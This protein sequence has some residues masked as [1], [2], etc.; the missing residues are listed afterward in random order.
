MLRSLRRESGLR[1]A[2]AARAR[3]HLDLASIPGRV[4]HLE[5]AASSA[6]RR[7]AALEERSVLHEFRATHA[8]DRLAEAERTLDGVARLSRMLDAIEGTT[9]LVAELP[10]SDLLITVIVPTY[11]RTD[12]LAHAIA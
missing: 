6:E 11:N 4:A 7:I 9:A 10:P 1:F 5:G 12:E 8:E 3:W 2:L